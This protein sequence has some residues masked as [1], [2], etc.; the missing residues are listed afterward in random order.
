MPAHPGPKGR[1]L[2]EGKARP[3]PR[4]ASQFVEDEREHQAGRRFRQKGN[5]RVVVID[6]LDYDSGARQRGASKVPS[7]GQTAHNRPRR[8]RCAGKAKTDPCHVQARERRR[9]QFM[10]LLPRWMRPAIGSI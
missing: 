6:S 5:R 3:E 7:N 8:N 2:R 1:L 4:I 9:L 10:S